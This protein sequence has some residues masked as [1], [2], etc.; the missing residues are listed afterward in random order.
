MCENKMTFI[1][2]GKECVQL[3]HH[4]HFAGPWNLFW[5]FSF[6]GLTFNTFIAYTTHF[7]MFHFILY[8]Y[9]YHS[10]SFHFVLLRSVLYICTTFICSPAHWLWFCSLFFRSLCVHR[11]VAMDSMN[12]MKKAAIYTTVSRHILW[13]SLCLTVCVFAW[14]VWGCKIQF[15]IYM[16]NYLHQQR[17]HKKNW[18][19]LNR[20]GK[21]NGKETW[22]C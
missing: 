6:T 8:I 9:F 1:A 14:L 20:C 12:K 19:W 5:N 3:S 7:N 16:L 22:W 10:I 4:I 17:R 18:N 2:F 15:S 11:M 21:R 13:R